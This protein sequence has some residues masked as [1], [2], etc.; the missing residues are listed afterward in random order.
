MGQF[1]SPCTTRHSQN[2]LGPI[3]HTSHS[4]KFTPDQLSACWQETFHVGRRCSGVL[5][6]SRNT[7][8]L[9]QR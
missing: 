9:V 1:S 2:H 8:M 7:L 4:Q 5:V 3:N 6:V